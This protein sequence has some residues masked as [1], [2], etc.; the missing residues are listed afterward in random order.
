MDSTFIL[1]NFLLSRSDIGSAISAEQF[2]KELPADIPPEVGAKIYNELA[3]QRK[4]LMEPVK[5]R[6]KEGFDIPVESSESST[7]LISPN[8]KY[9]LKQLV[10]DMNQLEKQLDTSHTSLDKEI[11]GELAAIKAI[12]DELNDLKYGK[13]WVRGGSPSDV[14]IVV[15]ETIKSIE[16]CEAF[17]EK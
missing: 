1:E 14:D 3:K 2:R 6:I 13:S 11:N 5:G 10:K 12:I 4:D 17:L 7:M 8:G 15:D 9:S 16:K